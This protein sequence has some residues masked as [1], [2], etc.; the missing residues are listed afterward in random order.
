MANGSRP[1]SRI[2]PPELDRRGAH[3]GVRVARVEVDDEDVR[4]VEPVGAAEPAVQ[5]DRR[6]AREVDERVGVAG[7]DVLDRAALLRRLGARDPVREVLGGALLDE[8]LG[9]D[10][11]DVAL[12][13]QRATGDVR[14]HRLGDAL[15]VAR[16]VGLRLARGEELLVRPRDLDGAAHEG[17]SRTTSRAGL[18]SRRPM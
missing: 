6:L 7:D 11:V 18:S 3:L 10:A 2:R 12:E 5:R 1:S 13:V 14:Q 9:L 17:T 4:A 8:A 15:V 16:E